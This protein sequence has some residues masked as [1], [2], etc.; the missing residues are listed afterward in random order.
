TLEE[1]VEEIRIRPIS[2]HLKRIPITEGYV[3]IKERGKW[4]QI[5]DEDRLWNVWIPQREKLQQQSLQ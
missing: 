2:S 4:R 1:R 5:C 3:E